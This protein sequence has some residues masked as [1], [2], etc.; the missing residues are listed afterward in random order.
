M[1][2]S[3]FQAA[4]HD[5]AYITKKRFRVKDT[6]KKQCHGSMTTR[7]IIYFPQ[8]TLPD[9]TSQRK[10][11]YCTLYT[12]GKTM[13]WLMI[14]FLTIY[15]QNEREIKPRIVQEIEKSINDQETTSRFYVRISLSGHHNHQTERFGAVKP[16]SDAM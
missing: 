6:K 9:S 4:L 1:I 8:H 3:I 16:L 13:L 12:F 10:V 2:L 7:K 15:M 5:H 11:G 14:K